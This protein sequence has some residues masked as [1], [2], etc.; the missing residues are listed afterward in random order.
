MYGTYFT[1]MQE[2]T[3][4][5]HHAIV[6]LSWKTFLCVPYKILKHYLLLYQSWA[7]TK[8][9]AMN[10]RSVIRCHLTQQITI[11][12]QCGV[13]FLFARH[14]I[15]LLHK[16]QLHDSFFTFNLHFPAGSLDWTGSV[17]TTETSSDRMNTSSRFE[18]ETKRIRSKGDNNN[19]DF[20]Y[21]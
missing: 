3:E 5:C 16:F 8:C 7:G 18:K 12:R 19:R 17:E 6:Q 14:E 10:Q 21:N 20:R 2:L 13:F 1:K 9:V 4:R 15:S 11:L